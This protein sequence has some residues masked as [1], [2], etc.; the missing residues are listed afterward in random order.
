MLEHVF[1]C[2]CL[3]VNTTRSC[4]AVQKK[5]FVKPIANDV[6]VFLIDLRAVRRAIDRSNVVAIASHLT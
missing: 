3:V 1:V 5:T 4:Y 6:N 2:F